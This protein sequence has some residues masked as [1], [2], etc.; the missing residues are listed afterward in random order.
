MNEREAPLPPH[1]Q[2]KEPLGE[3]LKQMAAESLKLEIS[4]VRPVQHTKGV[5]WSTR[6]ALVCT[7]LAAGYA[8]FGTTGAVRSNLPFMGYEGN[9]KARTEALDYL[10]LMVVLPTALLITLAA[11]SGLIATI[12]WKRSSR[13]AR[14]PRLIAV[15]L[16]FNLIVLAY[17]LP[18]VFRMASS[19][20]GYRV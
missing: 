7:V 14:W 13:Q 17:L 10:N 3:S 16:V 12:F 5:V 11:L 4:G 6:V 2:L 20:A 18:T 9:D 19:W 15:M 8:A 1:A